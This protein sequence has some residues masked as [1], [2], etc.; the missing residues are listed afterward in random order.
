MKIKAPSYLG[1]FA[2][3]VLGCGPAATAARPPASSSA[4]TT[5]P[6]TSDAA[7]ADELWAAVDA[8]VIKRD[9]LGSVRAL[10]ERLARLPP[11]QILRIDHQFQQQLARAHTWELWGA[12]YLLNGGCSD[13]CFDYFSAWLLMQGS[14]VFEAAVANPDSLADYPDLTQPV[15]LEEA[16]S[17]TRDV[18][19]S[20][21]GKEPDSHVPYPKLD[22][23]WDLDDQAQQ[24]RH[25]PKLC[26]KFG[27]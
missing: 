8:S 6:S 9:G 4:N 24:R 15:E 3:L 22:Q 11:E 13:D 21:T 10:H 25:Y 27:C 2:L 19:Q 20:V 18:Y 23:G 26:A 16:L 5:R 14:R 1:M 7:G 12:A 17:V